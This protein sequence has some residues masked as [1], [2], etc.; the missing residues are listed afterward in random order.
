MVEHFV[1]APSV[2]ATVLAHYERV[3]DL[4]AANFP[5]APVVPVYYPDGLDAGAHYGGCVHDDH[6]LP[7]TVPTVQVA[8]PNHPRR[9]VAATADSLLWLVHRGA[10]DVGSWTPSPHDPDRLGHARIIL[11]PRGGATHEHVAFAMLAL[12]TVLLHYG[13]EAIPVLDGFAGAALFIP[14][15]DAPAY[16]AVRAWLHVVVNAAVAHSPNLITADPHDQKSQRVH[17]NVGSNAPGRFS[18]LPYA[19]IGS[20]H[21][22]MVTPIHWNELGTVDNGHFTATNSNERLTE[23][24]VFYRLARELHAQRFGD[25][26]R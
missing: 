24:D 22:G 14:F 25:G 8:F 15:N 20:T 23:G 4:I 11:S 7:A 5:L 9:Y 12:R 13:V 3:A 1:V 10:I 26:P 21:L 16:D 6:P 19:L 18:S 2:Q 17:A